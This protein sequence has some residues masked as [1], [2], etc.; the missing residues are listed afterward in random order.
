MRNQDS[1]VLLVNMA[2]LPP[3]SKGSS[4]MEGIEAQCWSLKPGQGQGS[5]LE[6]SCMKWVMRKGTLGESQTPH[7]ETSSDPEGWGQEVLGRLFG[8]FI[9][10]L[11]ILLF[12]IY[13]LLLLILSLKQSLISYT[14][15]GLKPEI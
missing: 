6:L 8:G 13:L 1:S 4:K 15:Q 11:F 5:S 14:R 12:F 2:P 3:Y 10:Y 7:A 9:I